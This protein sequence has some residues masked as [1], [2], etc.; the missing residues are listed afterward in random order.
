[1]GQ[2]RNIPTMTEICVY[3]T[4]AMSF[5]S[6]NMCLEAWLAQSELHK[7]L[8]LR[9]MSLSPTLGVDNLKS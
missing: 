4:S 5:S 3:H 8:E 6:I 2:R 7:T 9:V 1:M